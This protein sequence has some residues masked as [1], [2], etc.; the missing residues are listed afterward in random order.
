MLAIQRGDSAMAF[1]QII[2]SGTDMGTYSAE[3]A[4]IAIETMHRD[5][6]YESSADAAT[7]LSTTVEALRAELV[8]IHAEI[9]RAGGVR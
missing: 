8:V 6:G 3:T 9:E 2:A 1:F 5:A 7:A 4:D